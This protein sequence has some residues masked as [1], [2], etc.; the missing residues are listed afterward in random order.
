M[1]MRPFGRTGEKSLVL[2]LG[3]QRIVDEHECTEQEASRMVN[4]AFDNGVRLFDTAWI[5]SWGQSEERVGKVACQRRNGM[6]IATKVIARTRAEA[7]QQLE[8]SLR[9]LQ[10]GHVDEWRFHHVW[11]ME[12]LDKITAPGGA[13]EAAIDARKG[14]VR[15]ISISGHTGPK[16]QLEALRRFPFDSV[17]CPTS[18]LHHFMKSSAEEFLPTANARGVA[19][20]GMNVMGLGL[21]RTYMIELC[22]TRLACQSVPPWWACRTW[23]SLGRISTLPSVIGLSATK[24]VSICSRKYCCW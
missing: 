11:S 3:A 21:C 13:L 20:I 19:V 12:E 5:Y 15:Y 1:E 6:W 16:V 4:H 24:N 10:T 7:R 23:S 2:S 17:G 9:R 8:E 14:L 18:V 22:A